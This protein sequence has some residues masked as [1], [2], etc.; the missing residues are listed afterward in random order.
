MIDMSGMADKITSLH[1]WKRQGNHNTK[2]KT[3]P[4]PGLI[5][6]SSTLSTPPPLLPPSKVLYIIYAPP[7][8]SKVLYIIYAPPSSPSSKVLVYIIYAPPPLPPVA[9]LKFSDASRLINSFL[10]LRLPTHYETPLSF[11]AMMNLTAPLPYPDSIRQNPHFR[12]Y[13]LDPA[14]DFTPT[15]LDEAIKAIELCGKIIESSLSVSEVKKEAMVYSA[16]LLTILGTSLQL[17]GR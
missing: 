4:R 3:R 6:F 9:Y 5:R 10:P 14:V 12:L 8:P 16:K 11:L 2:H 15:N 7:S 13:D 1:H 17:V